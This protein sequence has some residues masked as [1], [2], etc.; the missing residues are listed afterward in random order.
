MPDLILTTS[1]NLLETFKMICTGE[2]RILAKILS[3]SN[4][5]LGLRLPVPRSGR[6]QGIP[7]TISL[8]DRVLTGQIKDPRRMIFIVTDLPTSVTP[9]LTETLGREMSKVSTD[10]SRTSMMSAW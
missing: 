5:L 8:R 1:P 9:F 3:I 7:D 6:I 2:I 4:R 10:L